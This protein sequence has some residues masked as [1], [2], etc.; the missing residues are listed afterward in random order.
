KK[1]ILT[2]VSDGMNLHAADMNN[3]GSVNAID[4]ALL[5]SFLLR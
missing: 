2:G 5:K 4:L 3:D 1:Y